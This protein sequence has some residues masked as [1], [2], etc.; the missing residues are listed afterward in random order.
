MFI[1]LCDFITII[2]CTLKRSE[3]SVCPSGFSI[4]L[5]ILDVTLDGTIKITP[6]VPSLKVLFEGNRKVFLRFVF[7]HLC[8]MKNQVKLLFKESLYYISYWHI[9]MLVMQVKTSKFSL[10]PFSPSPPYLIDLQNY[11]CTF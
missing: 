8:L 5:N 11:Q 10:T 1:S 2:R 7:K 3:S 4:P 6:N 9:H